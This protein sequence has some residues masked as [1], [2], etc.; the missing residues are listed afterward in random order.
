[1]SKPFLKN[2]C[3]QT[4]VSCCGIS[5]D[6]SRQRLTLSDFAELIRFA[7]EV[8]LQGAFRRMCAGEIVN[9]S[10]NR[11]ALHTSLREFDAASPF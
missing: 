5:L 6:L 8:D 3:L 1:M 2:T 11:A 10:E 9:V 7:E 4:S